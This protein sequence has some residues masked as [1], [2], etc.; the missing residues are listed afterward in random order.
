MGIFEMSVIILASVMSLNSTFRNSSFANFSA[1]GNRW[2]WLYLTFKF[3][4][5]LN[6]EILTRS[7]VTFGSAS[8]SVA[9][10]FGMQ[11]WFFSKFRSSYPAQLLKIC[12]SM[13]SKSLHSL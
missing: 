2:I 6:S 12:S 9:S 7:C 11:I 3:L 1:E 4:R 10:G 13:F 8:G 5:H